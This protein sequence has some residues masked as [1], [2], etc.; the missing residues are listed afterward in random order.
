MII[1][2][3]SRR[4]VKFWTKHLSDTKK[5]DRAE[6][7]EKRGLLSE[8][9]ADLLTEIQDNAD[10]TRCENAMYIASFSPA[11]GETLT[12]QQWERAYEIFENQRG[13]P[14]G[15]RRIVYEH[16]KEGRTHRHVV[17]DRIDV[18]NM[19]AFPDGL[20]WKVCAA[21]SL[22]IS[23]ELDLH[24]TPGILYREEGTPRPERNPEAWEM[25]RGMRSG[26]DPRDLKAEL[27]ALYKESQDGVE[28]AAK[29][30]ERGV[31]LCVGDRGL[32]VLDNAGEVH[33]LARRLDGIRA[34]ELNA[35]MAGVD[36]DALPTV[37]EAQE[38]FQQE[39][40]AQHRAELQSVQSE[41]QRDDL[42][43]PADIGAAIEGD[44]IEVEQP[45]PD[46][47]RELAEI[48]AR[49][50]EHT[51]PAEP[52]RPEPGSGQQEKEQPENDFA[53]TIAILREATR[54]SDGPQAF[55]AAL[56][57]QNIWLAIATK[58][59]AEQS[60]EDAAAA[61]EQGGYAPTIREGEIVAIDE[62]GH[63][64]RFNERTTGSEHYSMQRYLGTSY[65]S[66]VEGIEDTRRM[67]LDRDDEDQ[68]HR[69]NSD[70][71][72]AQTFGIV[73]GLSHEDQHLKEEILD[74]TERRTI[75]NE[76]AL[77]R[78]RNTRDS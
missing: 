59:E 69:K 42:R 47:K 51:A 28:F 73:D 29:L 4:S 39:R 58:D 49:I 7:V 52:A 11:I 61:K 6:M 76:R 3:A 33:S 71:A 22:A 18:E 2:G 54:G 16:E 15:Q 53:R 24:H 20:D 12:E 62:H 72:Y 63:S 70:R 74:R 44:T 35:F 38:R 66:N 56:A 57:D 34:K 26:I 27:T 60:R 77:E 17:W 40:A 21:A 25:F 8:N 55:R 67:I 65:L 48:D 14:E 31:P 41:L 78:P 13:I 10:L 50:A 46:W 9:L 68:R 23:T 5:N 19:R 1:N 36:R 30:E 45:A 75:E 32:C 43:A 64:Y 37:A